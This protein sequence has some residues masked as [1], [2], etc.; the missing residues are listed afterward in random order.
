MVDLNKWT[1]HFLQAENIGFKICKQVRLA[2]PAKPCRDATEIMN[3]FAEDEREFAALARQFSGMLE[4]PG[5]LDEWAFNHKHGQLSSIVVQ[6][7]Q[8]LKE[9]NEINKG[10]EIKR[11]RWSS[12][13]ES[14]L[15]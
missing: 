3:C 11:I 4:L 1:E 8:S 6:L 13:E 2:I 9:L 5:T 12:G 14:A 10:G 7:H 15:R